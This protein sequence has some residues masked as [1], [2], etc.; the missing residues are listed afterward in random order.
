MRSYGE[1]IP[2][3]CTAASVKRLEAAAAQ[4]KE[5]STGTRRALLGVHQE[6]KRCLMIRQAMTVPKT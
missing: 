1:L 4:Y 6:D 3:N 5:L 2:A